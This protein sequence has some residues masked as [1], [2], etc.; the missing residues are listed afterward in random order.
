M[1]LGPAMSHVRTILI[2]VITLGGA[3]YLSAS[4][5]ATPDDVDRPL[6]RVRVATVD[7]AT[8][9]RELSFSGVTRAVDRARLS[10]ALGGRILERPVEVGD[11]VRRGE[12]LARL[13]SF[14]AQN[15]VAAARGQLAELAARRAQA[16]RDLARAEALRASKAATIEE[17]EHVRAGLDAVEAAEASATA[18]LREAERLLGETVLDAPFDGTVTA[19]H[20]EPGELAT[21][22][23]PVVT[24]SGD[25][26]LEVEIEVPES[27]VSRVAAGS[28]V[29][30]R[31]PTL[32]ETGDAIDATVDSV[33]RAAGGAGRLF[34]VTVRLSA[35]SGVVVGA[36]AEVRLALAQDAALSVPVEAV[37][38]PGG[39]QP[40]VFAIAD[41]GRVTK[42]RVEI[43]ALLGQ[44]VVV[45][46]P[47]TRLAAGDRVVVGG[48]RG[49][50]DGESVEVVTS[51]NR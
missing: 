41:D 13:E 21:P 10:F 24:L 48:Q 46:A 16:E 44:R 22:G 30:V 7:Q 50:L 26:D 49:L 19:V 6:K 31:I 47:E 3:I 40:A 25:G 17:V 45:T 28:T 33:S 1:T 11:R 5:S 29:T 15:T 43:G 36:T 18:R 9:Q 4:Q 23:R 34:P 35:A 14:E 20:F 8:E 27:I 12:A 39:R 51:E 32:G 37:I 38:D 2:T 42:V